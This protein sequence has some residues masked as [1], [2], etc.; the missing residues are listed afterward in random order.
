MDIHPDIKEKV[1]N[2]FFNTL[3][4]LR[5]S[6]LH[7]TRLSPTVAI[8]SYPV[9]SS[10]D[11]HSHHRGPVQISDGEQDRNEVINGQVY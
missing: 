7:H 5:K 10:S 11:H 9:Q 4:P 3:E 8:D 6:A 2:T 1:Q